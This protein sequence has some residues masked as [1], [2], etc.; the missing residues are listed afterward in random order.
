M[1]LSKYRLMKVFWAYLM[2]V[3]LSV[4]FFRLG[5]LNTFSIFEGFIEL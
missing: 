2:S 1:I 5:M 4:M 3:S